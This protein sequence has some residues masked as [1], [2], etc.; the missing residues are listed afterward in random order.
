MTAVVGSEVLTGIAGSSRAQVVADL[1]GA[2]QNLARIQ[3]LLSDVELQAGDRVLEVGCGTGRLLRALA[4]RLPRAA[5][6]VGIDSDARA[7][8]IA[9]QDL[10]DTGALTLTRMD[11]R[12]LT[13]GDATFDLVCFS[14]VFV[15]AANPA[16][17]LSEAARVLRPG[18]RLLL[19][20]PA[21]SFATGIDDGLRSRVFGQRHPAI[22]RELPT[23]LQAAGFRIGRLRLN[24]FVNSTHR[25]S[26]ALRHEFIAGRGL[27]ALAHRTRSCTADEVEAYLEAHERARTAN[28]LVEV[29][30]HAQI[31][32]SK[33][34][35]T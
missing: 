22:G 24:T 34:L 5:T 4:D 23:L 27:L 31:L 18:G 28:A 35:Q 29:V 32:A 9:R 13:F 10:Q 1:C 11:G 33:Q 15:H 19:S 16:L 14:R 26:S 17:L 2:E 3:D 25:S 12:A 7:L 21:Q 6:L 30:T 8:A 20:E